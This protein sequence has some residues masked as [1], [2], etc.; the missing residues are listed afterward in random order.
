MAELPEASSLRYLAPDELHNY[1]SY[2]CQILLPKFDLCPVQFLQQVVDKTKKVL[3]LYQTRCFYLSDHIKTKTDNLLQY[4]RENRV[5]RQYVPDT[6][7]NDRDFLVR[8]LATLDL[9]GLLELQQAALCRRYQVIGRDLQPVL[10]DVV[11]EDELSLPE[12]IRPQEIEREW[13]SESEDE[14]GFVVTVKF[15]GK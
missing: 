5:L 15:R 9:E 12:A 2:K 14:K 3:P 4:C 13:E 6:D 7:T 1:L 11:K 10:L 8:L